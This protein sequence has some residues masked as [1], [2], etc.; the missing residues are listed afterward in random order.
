[1]TP[2]NPENIVQAPLVAALKAKRN[3]NLLTVSEAAWEIGV[4]QATAWNLIAVGK[5]KVFRPSA[6]RCYVRRSEI[7][8]FVESRTGK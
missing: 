1:M 3:P 8:R 2:N 7:N 6:G 4:S 5:L